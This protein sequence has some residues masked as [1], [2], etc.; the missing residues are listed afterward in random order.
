[1]HGLALVY[2]AALAGWT[3]VVAWG[4]LRSLDVGDAQRTGGAIGI[5]VGV[6]A[7]IDLVRIGRRRRVAGERETPGVGDPVK[8]P[9]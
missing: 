7:L 6:A 4:A 8:A 1:M 9:R 3:Y 2:G 5:A